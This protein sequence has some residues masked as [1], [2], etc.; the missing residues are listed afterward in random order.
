MT[1]IFR[2]G[3]LEN[4]ADDLW[5]VT[6]SSAFPLP[7]NMIIHRLRSGGLFLHSVVAMHDE[8]MDALSA[9]GRPEVIVVPSPFHRLDAPFFR[10]RYPDAL[11]LCPAAVRSRVEERVPIQGTCEDRLEA[12][13][14]KAHRPTGLKPLEL[15]YELDV[16]SDKALVFNDALFHLEHQP[17]LAGVVL[18]GLGSTGF[19]GMSRLSRFTMLESPSD[20]A[21]WLQR[22][23]ELPRLVALTVSHGAAVTREVPE[24]LRE[25]AARLT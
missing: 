21:E 14:I 12:Y 25:A 9:L 3:P 17:G 16:G 2:H 10:R 22:M 6:G 13:G 1:K 8:G 5:M 19:F 18:R 15:V 7:R 4:V 23:A 11:M 20:Y 24:R